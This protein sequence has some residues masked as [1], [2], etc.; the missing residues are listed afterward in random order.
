MSMALRIT[1]LV[2]TGVGLLLWVASAAVPPARRHAATLRF[3]VRCIFTAATLLFLVWTL[4]VNRNGGFLVLAHALAV[5]CAIM[6]MWGRVLAGFFAL[7]LSSLFDGGG[8]RV[9]PE[10]L[11]SPAEARR[12]QGRYH[13]ALWEVQAQLEKFPEDFRGQMLIAEIQAENLNDLA[14]AEATIHRICAQPKHAPNR[15][16]GA[17]VRLAD[18]HI[19]I[20]QDVD[21]ARSAFEEIIQR[22]PGTE[23]AQQAENRIAHLADAAT[24]VNSREPRT[25]QMLATSP[26]AQPAETVASDPQVE[27][28]RLVHHLTE[29]PNDTEAREELAKV[30]ADGF[31]RL[32]LA[33]EQLEMLIA[34]PNESPRHIARWLNLLADLQVRCTADTQL[35]AVTIQRIIDRFQ[36]HAFGEAARE[37]LQYLALEK[38]RFEHA[39]SVKM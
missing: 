25:I 34:Q 26:V 6:L 14:G 12:K 30:Y 38:K 8:E 1:F 22:F 3:L 36:G 39:K 20:D 35:A 9:V 4:R 19:S 32:D 15:I 7:P 24:L 10:P 18:W 5:V 13:E 28:E 23:L 17:L 16:A 29:F 33:T 11:Y 37:R 2:L 21:A 31:Q 27:A